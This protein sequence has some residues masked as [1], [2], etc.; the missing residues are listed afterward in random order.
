MPFLPPFL[1]L[2]LGA[3]RVEASCIHKKREVAEE[4]EGKEEDLGCAW[5]T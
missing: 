1:L 5:A 4:E 3:K 2:L